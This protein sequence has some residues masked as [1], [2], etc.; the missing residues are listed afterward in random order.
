MSDYDLTRALTW[1]ECQ[2]QDRAAL[3]S[4]LA[5]FPDGSMV[6]V[7]HEDVAHLLSHPDALL[8]Y[9]SQQ[10]Q[11]GITEGLL[12]RF[13]A[14]SF[15]VAPA[16]DHA[17][18]RALVSRAFA[19]RLMEHLRAVARNAAEEALDGLRPGVEFDVWETVAGRVPARVMCSLLGIPETYADELTS[20]IHAI[21]VAVF[22]PDAS[23]EV[24]DRAE[25]ALQ[26]LYAYA[27]E[28][29]SERMTNPG[30]DV[31]SVLAVAESE[32]RISRTELLSMIT[33]L[34]FLGT[35]TARSMLGL[36]LYT[37]AEHPEELAKLNADPELAASATE[38]ILR[39]ACPAP[40]VPRF[41]S[42]RIEHAGVTLEPGTF[43]VMSLATAGLDSAQF[44]DPWTFN[45]ERKAS[46]HLAFGRGR[47]ACIGPSLAR[48]EGQELLRALAARGLRL[49]VVGDAPRFVRSG[50]VVE[51]AAPVRLRVSA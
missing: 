33:M 20:I 43:F 8:G 46:N 35:D 36:G 22:A 38:E 30:D 40:L 24:S 7:R 32:G 17:R 12:H 19:P 11:V 31:I 26:K 44:E 49:E 45:I 34:L 37:L 23:Q 5:R 6:F 50:A 13:V 10:E 16:A 51:P 48:L 28:L 15:P 9:G 29:S 2:E 25:R 27:G 21:S 3:A 39:F 47:H 42:Q 1:A 14:E 41:V 18:L 4:G